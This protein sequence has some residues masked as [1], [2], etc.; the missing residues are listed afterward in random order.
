MSIKTMT[1]LWVRWV[2]PTSASPKPRCQISPCKMKGSMT[3]GIESRSSRNLYRPNGRCFLWHFLLSFSVPQC[4]QNNATRLIETEHAFFYRYTDPYLFS[5]L[6]FMYCVFLHQLLLF[7]SQSMFSFSLFM[8]QEAVT[9][10]SEFTRMIRKKQ[11]NNVKF[12][13][14]KQTSTVLCEWGIFMVSLSSILQGR[15]RWKR[16]VI[17]V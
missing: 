10:F 7:T 15:I 1:R 16:L 2:K 12:S 11:W 9:M 17:I 5:L 3:W 6:S 13:L 8:K 4:F 14:K